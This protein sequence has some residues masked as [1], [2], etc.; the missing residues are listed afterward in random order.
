M[1]AGIGHFTKYKQFVGIMKGMPFE[2]NGHPLA[3]IV[4]GVFE[5]QLGALLLLAPFA[6]L[7]NTS[8]LL[9]LGMDKSSVLAPYF[10][11]K[12]K[13]SDLLFWLVIAM[14][15]ANINMWIN[16]TPFGK[17]RLN[18]GLALRTNGRLTH[19]ARGVMQVTLL[20]WL[21]ALGRMSE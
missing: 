18:Y 20:A 1:S 21:T 7:N 4:S 13:A 15:P 3:V 11:H 8:A 12:R 10:E 5:A 2:K 9:T 19:F 6:Q 16:D 17:T 14:T